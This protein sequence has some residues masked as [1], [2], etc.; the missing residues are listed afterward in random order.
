[1]SDLDGM[2]AFEKVLSELIDATYQQRTS[3]QKV[4]DALS[5]IRE[6]ENDLA[7]SHRANEALKIEQRK[8]LASLKELYE[9][10]EALADL[11]ISDGAP[12]MNLQA[13]RV[14]K[15]LTAARDHCDQLPF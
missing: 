15:A 6:L 5:R 13:V 4:A 14:R 3:D 10:A 2:D 8:P 7:T 1:M 11:V 9:S 12:S